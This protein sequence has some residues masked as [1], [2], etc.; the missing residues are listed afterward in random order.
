MVYH[1][2]SRLLIRKCWLNWHSGQHI[3]NLDAALGAR[4]STLHPA[5][6]DTAD[7]RIVVMDTE[8]T[9]ISVNTGHRVIEIGC[10]EVVNRSLSGRHLQIYL[11][12]GR[13]VEADAIRIHGITNDFLLD[14]PRFP[15][16][17]A[18][19]IEFIKGATVIFHNAAFD[20]GHLD[21][22]LSRCGLPSFS[23]HCREVM[24]TLVV[25]R[26]QNPGKRASLDALCDRYG[27]NRAGRSYHGALLDSQLLAEVYLLMTRGQDGLFGDSDLE[28]SRGHQIEAIPQHGSFIVL[29]ATDAELAAHDS[30]L[31]TMKAEKG[32]CIWSD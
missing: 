26:R 15:E 13:E 2:K 11:N 14:K 5:S 28:Q 27:V 25:A 4:M 24:D 20:L 16:V 18:Q 3:L 29:R 30:Y 8:T 6:G 19:L 31:A 12:P 22:E 1:I 10:V 17:S 32:R 9:G 7:E 21:G 23:S